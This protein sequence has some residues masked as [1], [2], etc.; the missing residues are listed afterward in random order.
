MTLTKGGT[1]GGCSIQGGLWHLLAAQPWLKEPKFW[2]EG[3]GSRVLGFRLLGFRVLEF[4]GL[5]L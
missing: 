5:G 4:R 3:L 1:Y 2:V